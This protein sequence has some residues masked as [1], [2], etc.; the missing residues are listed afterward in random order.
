MKE[1]DWKSLCKHGR[2]RRPALQKAAVD[3]AGRPR[4]DGPLSLRYRGENER[5][6]LHSGHRPAGA[7]KTEKSP[8]A[9]EPHST[10]STAATKRE[11][12]AFPSL[13]RGTSLALYATGESITNVRIVSQRPPVKRSILRVNSSWSPRQSYSK[14]RLSDCRH[15][16]PTPDRDR[17]HRRREGNTN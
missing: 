7:Q 15:E 3:G 1:A 6:Q 13:S 14:R 16:N 4:Q 9:A 11:L 17:K 8:T 2:R 5:R 12:N 10:A